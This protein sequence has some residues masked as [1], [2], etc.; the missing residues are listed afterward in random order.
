MKISDS[1]TTFTGY[2]DALALQ[3]KNGNNSHLI[4]SM[5]LNDQDGHEDLT[6][7]R[8]LKQQLG[9]FT[10]EYVN[11]DTITITYSENKPL[12]IS[13]FDVDNVALLSGDELLKAEQSK[14][15]FENAT[16]EKVKNFHM[17]AYTF[18]AGITKRL[19]SEND[20]KMTDNGLNK[21]MQNVHLNLSEKY[22]D[23]VAAAN[24]AVFLESERKH[25]QPVAHAIN[26]II[27][28]TMEVFFR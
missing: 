20:L 15:T 16:Y 23:V 17:K 25:V 26:E 1:K 4:L 13:I 11:N 18:L 14:I 10:D 2:S 27:K 22:K 5:Q 8:R 24:K 21:V 12:R 19:A 28:H 9:I 6:T 7:F 3:S